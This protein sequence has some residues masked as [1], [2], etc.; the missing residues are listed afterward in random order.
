[1]TPMANWTPLGP[2][3]DFPEGCQ[4]A[5]HAGDTPVCVFRVEG[6]LIAIENTCPHA[7]LPLDQGERNGLVLTCPYHAYTFNL[8]NG[9]NIDDP[10]DDPVRLLQVRDNK[11]V[12][13]VNPDPSNQD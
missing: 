1:M 4:I 11:G 6:K 10:N 3:N 12:I 8:R 9:A 13:E 2:A 7:G 5:A